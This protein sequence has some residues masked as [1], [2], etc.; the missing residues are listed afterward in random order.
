MR[1]NPVNHT[2][3]NAK[4]VSQAPCKGIPKVH[5]DFT[6]QCLLKF[7]FEANYN[8]QERLNGVIFT[9]FWGRKIGVYQ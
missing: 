7:A 5:K 4:A 6:L 1:L 2:T 9:C 8:W 3:F